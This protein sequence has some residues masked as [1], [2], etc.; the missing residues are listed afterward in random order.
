[1][2]KAFLQSR[3]FAYKTS[4]SDQQLT[5]PDVADLG[6]TFTAHIACRSKSP[7]RSAAAPQKRTPTSPSIGPAGANNWKTYSYQEENFSAEFPGVPK[8]KNMT[9]DNRQWVRGIQYIAND[10]GSEYLGQGLLYQPQIPRK[11]PVDTLL[12]TAIDGAKNAGKCR[13]RSESNY[14]FAGATAR[15]VIFEKCTGGQAAKSRF[16]VVRDWLY[17]ILAIGNPGV[18]A[19]ADT[20]RFLAS[21]RLI[22]P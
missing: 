9:V 5:P 17:L 22:K 14:S 13:I 3:G 4:P 12:R 11:Y 7:P 2:A 10:A 8:A 1:V 16:M 21:F 15:E 20:D 6:K 18:E 19:S